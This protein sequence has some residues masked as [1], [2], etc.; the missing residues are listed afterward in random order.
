MRALV[1][2]RRAPHGRLAQTRW[3]RLLPVFVAASVLMALP[4][5]AAAATDW[6]V[7]GVTGS[8]SNNCT[9]ALTACQTIQAAINKASAGDTIHVATGAY[10]EATSPGQPLKVDKTLT[11]LGAQSGVDARGRVAAESILMNPHGT[12]LAADKIVIDGFTIQD[13]TENSFTGYGIWMGGHSGTQILNN[14]F[15]DNIIGLGLSN[16]PSGPQ[17]LVKHNQFQH[18]NQPGSASGTGIYSDQYEGVGAVKN[19]LIL[20]NAFI[21]NNSSGIDISHDDSTKGFSGLDV[22]HNSFD[23]NGR[24]ILLFDTQN[25]TIHDNTISNSTT[26]LSA[27]IRI[28]DNNSDLSIMHNDLTNGAG[29]G[30][31]LS[32]I[33][34][35]DPGTPNPSSSVV[36]NYNN[37]EVFANEGLLVEPAGHVGTVDAQCNWWN[38]STG[39]KNANNPGGTGEEVVG[40]ADFTP[41]L[42][43][44]APNG[45]CTGTAAPTPG[46]VTGGGQITGDPV[47][48]SLGVLLSAPALVPSLADPKAQAT[49]GFVA[50]CCAPTGNLEYNDHQ[51]DVRIKAQS[52]T[53]LFI[54]SPGASCPATPGSKHARFTGMAAVIRSTGTTTEPY[55]VDVD[56]CGEPGTMDTFGIKTTTYSNGPS[57]LIGGNIQI[58]K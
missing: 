16:Q 11:L 28:F 39:P 43:A 31:R 58:H 49:F 51:M 52:V 18:N 10:P 36:I 44:R 29:R 38:S 21:G 2:A 57:V 46:K 7:N 26:P 13:S 34:A 14:V 32:D 20:E 37:L 15:Q 5:S 54:S 30:I 12:W 1:S 27:A 48:S 24:G 23:M 22:S 6:Y 4:V 50:K 8:D 3:L 9:S 47:F 17:V 55:T 56:D 19:V 25:T 53:G 35:V 42:I 33:D 40:D 45:A 41:W